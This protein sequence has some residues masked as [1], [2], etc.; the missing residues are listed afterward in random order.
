[1]NLVPTVFIENVA[2]L[3]GEYYFPELT[4]IG[5]HFGHTVARFEKQCISFC[6]SRREFED[7]TFTSRVTNLH[8]ELLTDYQLKNCFKIVITIGYDDNQMT[9]ESMH[10]INRLQHRAR[11]IEVELDF[12]NTSTMSSSLIDFIQ[13]LKVTAITALHYEAYKWDIVKKCIGNNTLERAFLRFTSAEYVFELLLQPQFKEMTVEYCCHD[14]ESDSEIRRLSTFLNENQEA[15][16]GKIITVL[17]MDE[18]CLEDLQELTSVDIDSV[19]EEDEGDEV[20]CA[21]IYC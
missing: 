20:L 13:Q 8:G 11:H 21:H 14:C 4:V 1:M 19:Y 16:R 17:D 15:I 10:Q 7:R 5:G 12:W 2:F 18:S 6:V 9:K 3:L